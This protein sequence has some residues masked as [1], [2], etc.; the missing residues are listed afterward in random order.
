MAQ[1]LHRIVAAIVGLFVLAAALIVWR[2]VR[3]ARRGADR[4]PG[5]ET[6]LA[7]VGT[8]AA[9]YAVQVIVGALQITHRPRRMG[10]GSPPR[11]RRGD[12]GADAGRRVRQLLRD[13]QR[14]RRAADEHRQPEDA[15]A[16]PHRSL[17]DR[18]KAYV[19]LTKPRIIELLL[20][21]T[22]PAMFLAAHGV[23]P[24]SCVVWTL[25]GGSLAAG[26]ANAINCY[27]DRDI[28][29]LM[30]RTRRR[31]LPA[32]AVNPEDALIFGLILG[33]IAFARDGASS[34]TSWR[35]S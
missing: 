20:V 13:A 27:L 11:P 33:V 14:A 19:A 22:V 17:G 24:S 23:P 34:P 26:A 3:A 6:I 18:V 5:G 29:L 4:V 15:A 30:T 16:G 8:A 31:P 2:R 1:F 32:H 7:L 28:D 25:V 35:R 21:T 10:R 12:L 9:L